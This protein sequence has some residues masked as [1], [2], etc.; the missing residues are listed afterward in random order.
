[1]WSPGGLAD[2][3]AWLVAMMREIDLQLSRLEGQRQREWEE[4]RGHR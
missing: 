1:M 4:S 2:Q 3:P